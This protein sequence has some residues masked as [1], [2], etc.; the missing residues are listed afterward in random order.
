VP[1]RVTIGGV[2]E[3]KE[4]APSRPRQPEGAAVAGATKPQQP[5]SSTVA[6]VTRPQ[7][8]DAGV[9][10][11]PAQGTSP[12]PRLAI[13]EI[14]PNL[15]V[16]TGAGANVTVRVTPGGVIVVDTKNPG[17]QFYDGLMAEIK[18]VTDKPV[19][20]VVVTSHN[21]DH[22]GNIG[23]F[24][25]AGVQVIGH[26]NVKNNLTVHVPPYRPGLGLQPPN[27]TYA[28]DRTIELGG[29]IVQ[30]RHAR[31]QTSGN[32]IVYFPD[33][34]V[35]SVGDCVVGTAP[36][37][38]FPFDGSALEWQNVL[39]DI[40]R[41]DF[42][43]LVPGHPGEFSPNTMT[44]AEFIAFKTKFDTMMARAKDLVKRDTPKESFLS[45]FKVDDLGWNALLRQLTNPVYLDPFYAELQAGKARPLP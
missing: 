24:I 14:K 4:P 35:V 22:G 30:I 39:D 43:T 17:D 44:R 8:T 31:A 45:Q 27:V 21:L 25:E 11:K 40:G 23:K 20:Y 32:S 29:V 36:F 6:K 26:D 2:E 19:R 37:L 18:K 10:S 28:K 1:D 38:D 34:K 42:D 33:L 7:E 9:D 3:S 41:L 16:V 15:Y 13:Q 12:Q 5:S